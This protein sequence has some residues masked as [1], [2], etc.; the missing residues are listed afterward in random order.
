M[1]KQSG[2][3]K[4]IILIVIG[5]GIISYFGLDV[6]GVLESETFQKNMDAVLAIF[7]K[8]FDFLKPVL[9][10]IW[11][12]AIEPLIVKPLT[13]LIENYIG[14]ETEKAVVDIVTDVASST[15]ITP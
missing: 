11:E 2:L 3:I 10:F 1:K 4:A 15:G 9:V 7:Q 14:N 5:V 8:I 12:K 13:G 6:A